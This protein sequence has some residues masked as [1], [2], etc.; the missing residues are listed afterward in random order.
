MSN[1]C[2]TAEA[3]GAIC[4]ASAC[5]AQ[6]DPCGNNGTCATGG[7]SCVP[8]QA[9][10]TVCADASCGFFNLTAIAPKTCSKGTCS[11]GGATQF[12]TLLTPCQNGVCGSLGAGG[13]K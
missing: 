12:C 10:G 8:R 2:V 9:E 1:F 3:G 11:A 7:G 5:T 13:A 6:T 4:C